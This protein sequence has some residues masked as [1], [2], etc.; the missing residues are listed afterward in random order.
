[1]KKKPIIITVIILA[2]LVGIGFYLYFSDENRLTAEERRWLN[3]NT[4]NVQN[5]YVVNDINIFGNLGEGIYYQFLED[6]TKDQEIDFNPIII[7]NTDESLGLALEVGNGL[8][9]GALDFYTDHFI[10]VGKSNENITDSKNIKNKNIGIL[11]K[12]A[13]Y[14]QK[15]FL[16]LE[17]NIF[18]SFETLD[19]LITN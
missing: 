11:T 13:E 2:F 19:D 5:I 16:S 4:A 18:T 3:D 7:T 10:L 14:I 9:T 17:E 1:M 8:P 15:Y 12:D 6:F